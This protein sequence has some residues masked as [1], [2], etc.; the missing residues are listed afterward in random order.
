MLNKYLGKPE[1]FWAESHRRN[2]YKIHRAVKL[3]LEQG[4]CS[5]RNGYIEQL[6]SLAKLRSKFNCMHFYLVNTG[7]AGSHWIEAMLGLLPGFYNGGEV[8]FPQ[9][10]KNHLET[11]APKEAHEFLDTVYL[12]HSGGVFEDSLIATVSNS[13]HLANHQQI[14]NHSLNKRVALLVRNPVDVAISRTFRKD[15]YK[16][17]VAPSLD[18]KEYLYRNCAYIEN[19]FTNLDESSFDTIIK[20]ENFVASPLRNLKKLVE[21]IGLEATEDQLRNSIE[22]TSIKSELKAVKKG[23]NAITNIYMGK[24]REYDWAKA[25][26]EERLSNVIKRFGY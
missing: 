19:F 24:R 10:I 11:L 14:S 21:L 25:Y 22:K 7:S 26:T 4:G 23:G 1:I 6:K 17:D 8:Y 9:K 2:A 12:L 18:D 5:S 20:Y 16:N 3:G 13:S 15:E